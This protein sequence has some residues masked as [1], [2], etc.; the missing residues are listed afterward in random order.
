MV[1]PHSVEFLAERIYTCA[2]CSANGTAMVSVVCD[3]RAPY[4]YGQTFRQYFYTILYIR[5]LGRNL[6]TFTKIGPREPLRRGR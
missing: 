1:V 5:H 2:L 6:Q 4:S 3:V